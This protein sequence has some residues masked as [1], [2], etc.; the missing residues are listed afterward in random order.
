MTYSYYP[1]YVNPAGRRRLR[2]IAPCF[3]KA[4]AGQY[5]SRQQCHLKGDQCNLRGLWQVSHSAVWFATFGGIR[6]LLIE[7][8]G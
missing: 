8:W 6:Y 3:V 7:W 4:L 1:R 5:G 2:L